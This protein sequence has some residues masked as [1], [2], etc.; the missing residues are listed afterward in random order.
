M[1][2]VITLKLITY[3][4]YIKTPNDKKNNIL[5]HYCL[6]AIRKRLDYTSN[7]SDKELLE[8]CKVTE[9]I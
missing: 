9:E 8:L 4:K 7:L 5:Q 3:S 6:D 2:V 1:N